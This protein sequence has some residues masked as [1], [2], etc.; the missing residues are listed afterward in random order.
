MRHFARSAVRTSN[1]EP[2]FQAWIA[3]TVLVAAYVA[4]VSALVNDTTTALWLIGAPIAL[5]KAALVASGLGFLVWFVVL[6]QRRR[7]I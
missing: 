2:F 3:T 4:G 1:P 7:D 6:R 5:A